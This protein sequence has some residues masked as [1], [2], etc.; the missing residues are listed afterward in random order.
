MLIPT[1]PVRTTTPHQTRPK[2][3]LTLTVFLQ[4]SPV[5]AMAASSTPEQRPALVVRTSA[6]L[7]RD[8]LH[9]P[10]LSATTPTH[11][12]SEETSLV[13]KAFRRST[14]ADVL[15]EGPVDAEMDALLQKHH[16]FRTSTHWQRAHLTLLA[17]GAEP[18][19]LIYSASSR[20]AMASLAASTLAAD[21]ASAPGASSSSPPDAAAA[22]SGTPA[23]AASS[24][25]A[26]DL[27]LE[28]RIERHLREAHAM[29]SPRTPPSAGQLQSGARPLPTSA[30]HGEPAAHGGL[31][32]PAG[33]PTMQPARAAKRIPLHGA[34]CVRVPGVAYGRRP[35]AFSVQTRSR[36]HLF[37]AASV[38][39]CERWVRLITQAIQQHNAPAASPRASPPRD[40]RPRSARANSPP[41]RAGATQPTPTRA[42]P[43]VTAR[44]PAEPSPADLYQLD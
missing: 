15:C 29:P 18:P 23:G 3:Q 39:E 35:F 5:E 17:G 33:S 8:Y 20:A 22:P 44:A 19:T 42:A 14:E 7:V 9:C 43:P 27:P 1:D 21:G 26:R 37:A 12:R 13:M 40:R 16:R 25:G 24:R 4:S 6:P 30:E 34:H 31:P 36:E 2:R 41:T 11:T 32:S 10:R 28:Q 38:E